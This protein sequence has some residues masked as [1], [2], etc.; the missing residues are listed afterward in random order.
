M[1]EVEAGGATVF[2]YVGA[3]LTPSEV[4]YSN[5][6]IDNFRDTAVTVNLSRKLW[7]AV[8]FPEK[9]RN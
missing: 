7:A 5:S 1:S 3:R 2:P 4:C 6:G 9:P 8:G